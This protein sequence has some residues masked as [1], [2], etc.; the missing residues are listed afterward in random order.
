MSKYDKDM[1]IEKPKHQSP[2]DT[3]VRKHGSKHVTP[4]KSDHKHIYKEYEG[5]T[6]ELFRD[7]LIP[8]IR[9]KCTIC[10]RDELVRILWS[11]YNGD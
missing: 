5:D 4:K 10:G 6:G 2:D 3:R 1:G 11:H 8:A 7:N 9:R